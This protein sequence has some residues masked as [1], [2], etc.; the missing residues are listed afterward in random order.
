MRPGSLSCCQDRDATG[1]LAHARAPWGQ[2]AHA[3]LPSHAAPRPAFEQGYEADRASQLLQAWKGAN[4]ITPLLGAYLADAYLGR[5]G[6]GRFVETKGGG[7]HCTGCPL[8]TP[9]ERLGPGR[10]GE[11]GGGGAGRTMRGAGGETG[12]KP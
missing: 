6:S 7:A 8:P 5:W 4:F 2:L 1:A 3:P 12:V 10:R 9:A 11:W